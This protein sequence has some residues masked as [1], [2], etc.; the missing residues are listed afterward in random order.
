M[1]YMLGGEPGAATDLGAL[2]AWAGS[3]RFSLYVGLW[4][5]QN[6]KPVWQATT[7]SSSTGSETEDLKAL[8]DF[9]YQSLS[10]RS[11]L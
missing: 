8:A 11:L 6:G 2:I 9:V 1:V 4:D 3:V 10:E 5:G 7:N